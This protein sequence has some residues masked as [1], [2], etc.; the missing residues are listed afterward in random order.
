MSKKILIIGG[1]GNGGVVAAC[2]ED[3]RLRHRILEWEV[4]GFINDYEQSVSGYPVLGGTGDLQ[5][6]LRR[7]PDYYLMWAIHTI[8]RNYLIEKVFNKANIP[9]ERLATIVHPSA[10]VAPTAHLEPG[11]FVMSN[12]YVGPSAHIG[13]CCMLMANSLVAHDTRVGPLC[14][15]SA[16]SITGSY[17]TIGKCSS[18]AYGTVVL[19]KKNIGNFA[20]AGASSLV[21]KD[22]PDGE[23][24]IGIPARFMKKVMEA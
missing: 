21:T 18:I 17:N 12:C 11:V 8:G 1:E 14:H 22:I 15:F 6:I 7:H 23:I 3:M 2:I 13:L 10:F 19:E 4:A 24:H 20:V 5:D 16:G 9:A